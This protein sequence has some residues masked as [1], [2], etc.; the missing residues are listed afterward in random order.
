MRAAQ[1][2]VPGR[3][4]ESLAPLAVLGGIDVEFKGGF[5]PAPDSR[6]SYS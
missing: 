1:P 2:T 5:I 6:R 4:T 3:S